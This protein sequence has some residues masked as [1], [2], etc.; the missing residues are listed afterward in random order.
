MSAMGTTRVRLILEHVFKLLRTLPKGEI[1][2]D[3]NHWQYEGLKFEGVSTASFRIRVLE[4]KETS[5]RTLKIS[6]LRS[7]LRAGTKWGRAE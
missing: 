5:H 4:N 2:N 1:V 3:Y 6:I 7:T